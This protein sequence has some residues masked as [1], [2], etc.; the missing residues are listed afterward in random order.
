VSNASV[1]E[2]HKTIVLRALHEKSAASRQRVKLARHILNLRA[3]QTELARYD[4]S[5]L[6]KS[7]ADNTAKPERLKYAALQIQCQI[8]KQALIGGLLRGIGTGI[9][10]GA[11]ALGG[12]GKGTKAL[13]GYTD[14]AFNWMSRM[15]SK[16]L[17]KIPS[18]TP[19][20]GKRIATGVGS[21][22]GTVANTAA[23][24]VRGT[25]GMVGGAASKAA[26]HI[27]KAMTAAG[28]GVTAYAKKKPA[29]ALTAMFAGGLATPTALRMGGSAANEMASDVGNY[30]TGSTPTLGGF[31]N[32]ANVAG[33]A[34]AGFGQ[35]AMDSGR[36]M[37]DT[38][39]QYRQGAIRRA[40]NVGR[41]GYHVADAMFGQ[42]P[43]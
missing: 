21:A 40:E 33:A 18:G 11:K 27:G 6:Q 2:I 37:I 39:N 12:L 35:G 7:A 32:S 20:L 28:T 26:P 1:R 41:R 13:G 17:G 25:A 24:A 30:V 31:G 4:V 43:Q 3:L 9:G 19:G 15:G 16:N 38:A 22:L 42:L 23:N 10:Y 36:N 34:A 8:E 29:Q 5:Q 14:D